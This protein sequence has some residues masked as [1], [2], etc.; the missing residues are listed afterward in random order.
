[1]CRST[2]LLHICLI[3]GIANQLGP[4]L[5]K[6]CTQ[7][8]LFQTWNPCLIRCGTILF[9]APVAQGLVSLMCFEWMFAATFDLRTT[10]GFGC[11]L[12]AARLLGAAAASSIPASRH[13]C[14]GR[15]GALRWHC[16][17]KFCLDGIY[18]ISKTKA[19]RH[20]PSPVWSR[21]QVKG[22]HI[23]IYIYITIII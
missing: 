18:S 1:M 12:G 13:A 15:P 9:P 23:Y 21:R 2:S 6:N 7:S 20:H 4:S 5:D 8:S 14:C 10:C 16:C 22:I 3:R 19:F 11:L 17:Q